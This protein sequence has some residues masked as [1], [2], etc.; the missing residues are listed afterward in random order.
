MSEITRRMIPGKLLVVDADQDR[1]NDIV[2]PKSISGLA[3]KT[4]EVRV[5]LSGKAPEGEAQ[6]E[7]GQL[8]KVH[9]GGT[10]VD[11]DG[12]TMTM[13][14]YSQILYIY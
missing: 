6:I 14:N 9:T 1:E 4:R 10:A 12:V 7:D 11:V 13:I 8:L 5:I 3:S 2:I